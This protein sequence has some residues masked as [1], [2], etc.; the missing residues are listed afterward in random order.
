MQGY[1]LPSFHQNYWIG[2]VA[3]D[4]RK[5]HWLD[6]T[7]FPSYGN[8]KYINWGVM[9]PGSIPEPNNAVSPPE[10]CA[11]ANFTMTPASTLPYRAFWA[12][13]GCS[14]TYVFMCR[15]ACG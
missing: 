11:V 5:W 2:A 4:E 7:S 8:S 3:D 10:L 6:K 9:Q 1:L 14:E 13:T 12:D 15:L